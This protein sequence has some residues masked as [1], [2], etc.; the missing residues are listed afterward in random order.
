MVRRDFT[1]DHSDFREALLN[2]DRSAKTSKNGK[3]H[4]YVAVNKVK[5]MYDYQYVHM[6]MCMHT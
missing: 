6:D 5:M 3:L 2:H 4:I 1:L